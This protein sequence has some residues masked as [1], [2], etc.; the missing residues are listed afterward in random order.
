MCKE[1][2]VLLYDAPGKNKEFNPFSLRRTFYGAY[3]DNVCL[4]WSSDSQALAVGSKDMS[5]RVHSTDFF[6]NLTCY[7][8]GGHSESIV[9]CFFDKN[10][11]DLYTISRNGRLNVWECDTPLSGLVKRPR[12]EQDVENEVNLDDDRINGGTSRLRTSS[13][14]DDLEESGDKMETEVPSKETIHYKKKAK[15]L[16]FRTFTF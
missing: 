11:L 16:N 5:T 12:N 7:V 14:G 10:S 15:Y 4:D 2:R 3:D 6:K 1:N 13:Q 9:G 8:L